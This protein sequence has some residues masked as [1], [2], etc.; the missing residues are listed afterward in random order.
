MEV[1]CQVFCAAVAD[2]HALPIF[3]GIPIPPGLPG[4]AVGKV[5]L[6]KKV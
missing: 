1:E 5:P 2:E 6:G 3:A 4:A